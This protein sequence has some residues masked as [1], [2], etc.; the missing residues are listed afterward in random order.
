MWVEHIHCGHVLLILF[1][2]IAPEVLI[3]ESTYS[4]NF[5]DILLLLL[6]LLMLYK[7]IIIFT[8]LFIK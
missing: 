7:M 6:L 8:V 5:L 4:F 1:T 2:M 3:M